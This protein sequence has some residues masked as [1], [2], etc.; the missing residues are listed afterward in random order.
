[1]AVR[2]SLR[3]VLEHVTLADIAGNDLPGLVDEITSDPA[4]WEHA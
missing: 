4:A 1:V 3:E 2:A